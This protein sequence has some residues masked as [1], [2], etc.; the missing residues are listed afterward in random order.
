[1]FEVKSKILLIVVLY[2]IKQNYRQKIIKLSTLKL[3]DVKGKKYNYIF[4]MSAALKSMKLY[5]F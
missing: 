1:M 2:T 3:K 4:A 5:F